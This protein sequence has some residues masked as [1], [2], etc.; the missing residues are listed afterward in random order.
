MHIIVGGCGR[1]GAELAERLSDEGHDVVVIDTSEEAFTKIGTTFNGESV[2]GDLTD[3]AILSRAGVERADALAAVT[4]SDNANLMAVQIA[5]RLFGVPHTVARLFNPQR[6]ASYRKMGVRYVSE[7]S[8]I[9]ASIR[10][11]VQPD[12]LPVH[13]AG[14]DDDVAVVE[15]TVTAVGRGVSVAEVERDGDARVAKVMRGTNSRV[16]RQ[17]DRFLTDDV[18]V[19]AVR[20][21]GMRRLRELLA[22]DA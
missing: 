6:E 5:G 22:G 1:V 3:K 12:S 18:V 10:N 15:V 19:C 17:D 20:R 7:T 21:A 2:V 8:M 9:V 4:P 13:L 16:P 11:D 14:S